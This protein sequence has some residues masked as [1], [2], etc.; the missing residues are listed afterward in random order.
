MD[1][2]KINTC[3]HTMVNSKYRISSIW[4]EWSTM[5]YSFFG[6]ETIIWEKC[7]ELPEPASCAKEKIA[8]IEET[9]ISADGVVK[10]HCVLYKK[11]ID[12]NGEW[13]D[14]ASD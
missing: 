5:N 10:R 14:T 12:N 2:E 13:L 8:H 7:G 3:I 6:W 4:R 1:N 11:I 9:G